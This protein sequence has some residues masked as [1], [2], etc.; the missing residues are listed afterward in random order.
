MLSW[1]GSQHTVYPCDNEQL[2]ERQHHKG[3]RGTVPVHDLQEVDA[4]LTNKTHPS[5]NM[6]STQ[7]SSSIKVTLLTG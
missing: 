3:E 4:T 7:H 2:A 1:V 6:P 5:V